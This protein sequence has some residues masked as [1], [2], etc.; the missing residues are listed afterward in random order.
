M[1]DPIFMDLTHKA[2]VL[3]LI[4]SLPA[5]LT[6]ALT[7]ILVSLVQAVTQVQDQTISFAI[8]LITVVVALFFS[9]NWIAGQI[10]LYSL[11]I[12]ERFPVLV[13]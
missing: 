10:L 11:N 4:L 7:G 1:I 13:R 9:G 12:F 6:A 8:K 5:I 2:L 3:V